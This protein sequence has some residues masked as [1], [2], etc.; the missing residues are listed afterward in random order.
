VAIKAGSMG[1]YLRTTEN[2]EQLAKW[3]LEPSW[4]SREML[5][6]CFEVKVMNTNGAGDCAI[7]GLIS[8]IAAGFEPEDA[9]TMAAAVGASSTESMDAWSGVPPRSQLHERIDSGWRR[10]ETSAPGPDWEYDP[11]CGLWKS[12]ID[13][14]V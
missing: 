9:L 10:T 12:G 3:G 1:L 2:L 11:H 14:S 13:L 4:R 5:A 8:S 6:P 7:A